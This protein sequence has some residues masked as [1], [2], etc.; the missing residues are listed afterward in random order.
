MN[1]W[2]EREREG[3]EQQKPKATKLESRVKNAS[4]ADKAQRGKK[5][6]EGKGEEEGGGAE[7]YGIQQCQKKEH[8]SLPEVIRCKTKLSFLK[9]LIPILVNPCSPN[10]NLCPVENESE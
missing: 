4:G 6:G 9:K 5:G 8:K 1:K 3:Q 2:R 10:L 7:K